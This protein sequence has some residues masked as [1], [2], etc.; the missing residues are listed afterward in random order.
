MTFTMQVKEEIAI[1]SN[2]Y[3]DILPEL[4]AFVK[5]SG[6][7]KN[8]NITLVM[9][10]AHVA[11]CV[12]K[13]FKKLFMITPHIQIRIQKRFKTKQIYILTITENVNKILEKLNI[14]KDNK[15]ILPEQYFL[16]TEEDKAS[17]LK[18][19]FL[20]CGSINDPKKSGYHLEFVVSLKK[21]AQ[22]INKLLKEFR[23]ESKILKRNNKYMIYIKQSEMISDVLKLFQTTNSLF[24]F[25][26]IRIY[27]DHKN[28]VNRLNNVDLANQEKVI[29]TGLKQIEDIKYLKKHDLINLLDERTQEVIEYRLKY[30]ETSFSELAQIVSLET[31][32]NISK[33]GI[34]HYFRK[35]KDLVNKHKNN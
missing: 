34:N 18:G 19:L 5:F 22:Y 23:I 29:E 28:M 12:Y 10:N 15:F 9:E 7:F 17:Y 31:E 25:E 16:D 2:D 6:N 11:R 24:Y 21:D 27:R 35:I 30:P 20:S 13:M 1:N 32:K 26:D 8:N 3:L 14:V 33:S 4:S